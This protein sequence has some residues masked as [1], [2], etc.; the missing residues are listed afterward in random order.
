MKWLF[1]CE[2]PNE[3]EVINILLEH[4]CL[5]VSED[6]LLGLT[7]YHARQIT[8]SAQVR[9]ELNLYPGEVVVCRIGDSQNEKLKIPAD[10]KEK[11]VEVRKYCTKPELEMLLIIAENL[12]SEYE[13][14]KSNTKPKDFAKQRIYYGRKRYDNS[15]AFYRAY[16]GENPDLLVHTIREYKRLKGSHKRDE[17][18]LADLLK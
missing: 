8:T 15:T 5:E 13:K 12:Y 6:D 11:I 9:T 14:V 7:S 4:H 3:R 1:M 18:Y 17:L 2:G 10:Y 16:F